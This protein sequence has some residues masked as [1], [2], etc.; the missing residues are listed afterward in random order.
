MLGLLLDEGAS[1]EDWREVGC[2]GYVLQGKVECEAFFLPG[3]PTGGEEGRVL[4]LAVR[5]T[6]LSPIDDTAA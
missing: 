3:F 1:R 4:N 5:T 2:R 6:R